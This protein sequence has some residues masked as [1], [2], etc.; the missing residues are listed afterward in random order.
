MID[1]SKELF[2]ANPADF[3]LAEKMKEIE[4]LIET[5]IRTDKIKAKQMDKFRSEFTETDNG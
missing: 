4:D 1:P 2:S 5:H 3:I